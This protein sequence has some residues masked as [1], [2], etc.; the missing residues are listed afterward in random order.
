MGKVNLYNH[1]PEEWVDGTF[2]IIPKSIFKLKASPFKLMSWLLSHKDG[3]TCSLYFIHKGLGMDYRTIYDA[4][5]SL[6][7]S[8]N[9]TGSGNITTGSKITIHNSGNITTKIVVTLPT[10][11]NSNK[12]SKK[13]NKSQNGIH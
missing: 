6:S 4:F 11:K 9:I 5:D 12:N 2:T 3:F 13:I 10:N 7:D 1:K 8:G